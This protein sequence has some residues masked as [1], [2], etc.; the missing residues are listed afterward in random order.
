MRC[1]NILL[2]IWDRRRR[3]HLYVIVQC[4]FILLYTLYLIVD[5]MVRVFVF[6]SMPLVIY[7]EFNQEENSG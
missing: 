7:Y 5:I 2:Y 4:V 6:G 3:H 1:G